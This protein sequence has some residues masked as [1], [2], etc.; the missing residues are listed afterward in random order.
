MKE[1]TTLGYTV[2]AKGV[3]ASREKVKAI[4]N[5]PEPAT[6]KQLR[7]VFGLIN[8]QRKFF[9]NAE[10]ILATLTAY[11]KGMVQN[12][13]RITLSLQAKQ[14]LLKSSRL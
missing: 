13:Q 1:I 3:K 11:L 7:Q 14:A 12:A 5:L 8:Y 2:S 6:I 10:S 9:C 4:Q